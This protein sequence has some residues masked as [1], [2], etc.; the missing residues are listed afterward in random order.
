MSTIANFN[1]F[2]MP[3]VQQN[4]LQLA[5][6][7]LNY[8]YFIEYLNGPEEASIEMEMLPSS[9]TCW[10]V[11][12]RTPQVHSPVLQ[13][14]FTQIQELFYRQKLIVLFNLPLRKDGGM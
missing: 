9:L 3:E 7:W 12:N 5:T 13:V 10:S 2:S 6:D 1:L 11:T 4:F 14:A 8:T